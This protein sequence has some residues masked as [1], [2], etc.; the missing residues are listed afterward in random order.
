MERA[1][2]AMADAE[3][4]LVISPH[5]TK[6]RIAKAEALYSMGKFE[7]ALVEFERAQRLR[8]DPEVKT[9]IV[10]CR[11]VILNTVGSGAMAYDNKVFQKVIRQIKIKEK[12]EER[13]REEARKKKKS[14]K[15]DTDQ[16]ILGKM[17][18]DVEFLENFITKQNI[19][20][21]GVKTTAVSA[22]D[23]LEKRKTFWQQ[24]LVTKN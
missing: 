1:T 24:T 22:L 8:Q 14:K 20:Q 23:Y 16:V 9:G 3:K 7:N 12:E 19:G 6:A 10:K 5:S 2:E 11:E 17:Q 18:E 13:K 15:K 21:K 4:A